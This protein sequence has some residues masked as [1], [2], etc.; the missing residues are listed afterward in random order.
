MK[1]WS[2]VTKNFSLSITHAQKTWKQSE[3]VGFKQAESGDRRQSGQIAAAKPDMPKD[4]RTW[5]FSEYSARYKRTDPSW[6]LTTSQLA[7]WG[8]AWPRNEQRGKLHVPP[9]ANLKPDR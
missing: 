1:T 5:M 7:S 9:F 3:T 2:R 8:T 4:P 6:L